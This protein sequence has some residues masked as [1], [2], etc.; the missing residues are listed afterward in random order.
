M[1]RRIVTVLFLSAALVSAF[2]GTAKVE[3]IA[4]P[5]DSPVS[6][7]V[8]DVLDTNGYRLT[9]DDGTAVAD[10]WLRKNIPNSGAKETEGVLFPEITPSTLLG[11]ISFPK[12]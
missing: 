5:A 3:R 10:V 4:R 12:A 2:A 6:A 9:L 1:I 11:V 7:T 8:W